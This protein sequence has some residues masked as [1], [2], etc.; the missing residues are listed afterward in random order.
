MA[1]LIKFID[2]NPDAPVTAVMVMYD[3]PAFAI[4]GRR[5]LGV[6]TP[7][8]LRAAAWARRPRRS[9]GAV[10]DLS[11]PRR[12][13]MSIQITIE[14]VGFPTREPMLAAG[15]VDAVTGFSF[16]SYLNTVRLGSTPTTSRSC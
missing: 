2:Q 6:T 15:E 3:K 13:W 5:S 9:L 8:D 4:V 1:S 11:P 14:P 7:A 10:P 16:T 12:A